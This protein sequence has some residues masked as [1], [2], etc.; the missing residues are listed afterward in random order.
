MCWKLCGRSAG[1]RPPERVED[2]ASPLILT[3]ELPPALQA[4]MD[5]LRRAHF[6]PERNHLSAH[7]TLFHALPPSALGEL[8]E[9][10]AR[11]AAGPAP[12]GQVE[13]VMSL[14]R[15]TAIR[16]ASP[17]LLAL[18]DDLAD[19]FHTLLT[20]QD[21]HRPR[22]H[23]TVQNKVTADAARAL[24]AQLSSQIGPEPFRFAA[25]ALH[26]YERGPWRH[27]RSFSFRG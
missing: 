4:R 12:A 25:L 24:Q 21:R 16:L 6:P 7:V 2:L 1:A 23:V 3:A 18:R 22:L 15:G 13:G 19:R 8:R 5:A 11:I 10:L 26:A 17:A 20:A 27:L 9:V 14:G